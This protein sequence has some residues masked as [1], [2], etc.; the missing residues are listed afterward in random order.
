ML[1][2][3]LSLSLRLFVKLGPGVGCKYLNSNVISFISPLP[4]T[5]M[6]TIGLL[7]SVCLSVCLFV[8]PSVRPSVRAHNMGLTWLGEQ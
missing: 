5:G 8:C 6:G 7:D 1:E 4:V 2:L 3:S